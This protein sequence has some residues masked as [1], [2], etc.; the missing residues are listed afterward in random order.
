ML[1]GKSHKQTVPA[2]SSVAQL[3][4]A[5]DVNQ[6]VMGLNPSQGT[7]LGRGLGPQ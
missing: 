2:V 5:S 4:G 7:L 1:S 3:V 6:K